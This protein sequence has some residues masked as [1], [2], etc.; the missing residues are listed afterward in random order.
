MQDLPYRADLSQETCAS[1]LYTGPTRQH[2]LDH[3]IGNGFA[4]IDL[5]HEVGIICT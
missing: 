4:L 5:D 1:G 2:E 3:E